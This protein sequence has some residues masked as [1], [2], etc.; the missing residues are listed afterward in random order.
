MSNVVFE[1]FYMKQGSPCSFYEV[2]LSIRLA[3]RK[4]AP[5]IDRQLQ[6][7]SSFF[8]RLCKLFLSYPGHSLVRSFG[9]G[10][11][12]FI[13]NA[14]VLNILSYCTSVLFI[15]IHGSFTMFQQFQFMLR[16][17]WVFLP[18]KSKHYSLCQICLVSYSFLPLLPGLIQ[19]A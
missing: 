1:K 6:L 17:L 18:I 7:E 16:K 19:T 14:R 10:C 5:M 11:Y 3:V 4:C 13:S 2:S 8:R 15:H 9:G 12:N